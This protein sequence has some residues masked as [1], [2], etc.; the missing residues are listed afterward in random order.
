MA[1][2]TSEGGGIPDVM[3]AVTE[4]GDCTL[5]EFLLHTHERL[6]RIERLAMFCAMALCKIAQ[7]ELDEADCIEI[8]RDVAMGYNDTTD[9][10]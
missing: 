1:E 3:P 8:V 5:E 10:E 7:P 2:A 4:E 6:D 9:T